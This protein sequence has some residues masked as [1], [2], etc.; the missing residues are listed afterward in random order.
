MSESSP[1]PPGGAPP[2]TPAAPPPPTPPPLALPAGGTPESS[3][4]RPEARLLELA[5]PAPASWLPS[6]GQLWGVAALGL[7]LLLFGVWLVSS[8]LPGLLTT[9]EGGTAAEESTAAVAETRRI[10]AALFYVADDGVSLMP[11]SREVVYGA[12]PVEQARRILEAQI[13]PPPEGRLSAIPTGTALRSVYL[14]GSG[15]AYVDLG[16]A[17]LSGHTGGSLAEALTV[18]AIVNVLAANL[19]GVSSVQI[20]VEGQEVDSLVGHL[21]LR[22]PIGR[23]LDWV[24]KGP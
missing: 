7:A 17:I 11:V 8:R 2:P 22:H 9:P 19:P 15:D 6:R 1:T 24:R 10:Q 4:A 12:T 13:A 3:P 16:G 20:L 21:D 14:T 23:A 5:P 18:Y